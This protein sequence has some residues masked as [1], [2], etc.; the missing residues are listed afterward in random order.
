MTAWWFPAVPR[1]R[2]AVL[3]VAV[4]LFVVVDVTLANRWVA[5]RVDVPGELYRPLLLGRL[6]HLPTPGPVLVRVVMVALVVAALVAATGR[7]PRAA[8]VA[9]L[10]LYTEWML[11]AFSYG[12]VDH[13]RFAFLVALAVLPTVGRASWRDRSPDEAA[14]WALRA[15]QVAVVATYLLAV[16]AKLR[17]GGLAWLD[18]ATLLR[19]VIRRGVLFRDVLLDHPEVLHAAQYLL[20]AFELAAPLLLLRGRIARAYLAAAFTFHAVTF[21]TIGIV[22]LP[23]LVAMLS[24]VPLERLAAAVRPSVEPR[25]PAGRGE[26]RWWPLARRPAAA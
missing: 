2:V 6:L 7:A 1:A 19:A 24:F 10:L 12:K 20:V 3:R 26:R 23:H 5:D 18:S 25:R 14:G 16:F 15:V 22:F 9:V 13:D 17:F 4:Y 8:G 21:A 11:V